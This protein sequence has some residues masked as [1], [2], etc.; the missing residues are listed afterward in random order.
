M[1]GAISLSLSV[2]ASEEST[3]QTMENKILP[4][5]YGLFFTL[6]NNF[7][8]N[9]SFNH[10]TTTLYMLCIPFLFVSLLRLYVS[11]D[12][13][14]QQDRWKFEYKEPSFMKSDIFIEI[15]SA[16][17]CAIGN[18]CAL[19]KCRGSDQILTPQVAHFQFHV[20]T[21]PTEDLFLVYI[22]V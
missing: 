20:Q 1:F 8:H 4:L 11:F 9:L 16:T 13:I 18:T 19:P 15:C 5:K 2:Y 21:I 7:Y 14:T 22:L 12:S 10:I 3:R 6:G 17:K